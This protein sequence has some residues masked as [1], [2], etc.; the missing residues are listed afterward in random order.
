M[1]L[2][3]RRSRNSQKRS[4]R[5]PVLSQAQ[6]EELNRVRLNWTIINGLRFCGLE[7]GYFGIASTERGTGYTSKGPTLAYICTVYNERTRNNYLH[8]VIL[9]RLGHVFYILHRDNN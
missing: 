9:E 7:V 3:W 5:N 6:V 1:K 4:D 8:S 2:S